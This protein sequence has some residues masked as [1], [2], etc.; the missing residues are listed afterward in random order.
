M[1]VQSKRKKY[2][3]DMYKAYLSYLFHIFYIKKIIDIKMS[4]FDFYKT[5]PW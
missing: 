1:L 2:E 5:N 3:F 4:N